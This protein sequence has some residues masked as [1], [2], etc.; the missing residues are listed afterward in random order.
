MA[1]LRLLNQVHGVRVVSPTDDSDAPEADAWAGRPEPGVLLG[2]K[3]ADCLPV[4]FCH[5]ASGRVGLAHAGWRGATAGV[6]AR[7]LKAMGVPAEESL[8]A[9]GPCIRSCCYEVGEDV[10]TAAG[11]GSPHVE[12]TGNG[13]YRFDLQGF[14]RSQLLA[15]GV[16]PRNIDAI[17]HCTG[18]RTDLFFS[19]RKEG[20]TGRL[21][22][23][24]GWEAEGRGA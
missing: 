6:A 1:A 21:C 9:L 18:C 2:I 24:L 14:V 19:F 20:P 10:V 11:R 15:E 3:T 8:V 7:T 12:A 13:K 4:A 5:P 22:A 17:P 23:F 16:D